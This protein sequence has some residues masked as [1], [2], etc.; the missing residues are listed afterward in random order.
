MITTDDALWPVLDRYLAGECTAAEAALVREWLL[1]DPQEHQL[2]LADIQRIRNVVKHRPQV[3]SAD[4]MWRNVAHELSVMVSSNRPSLASHAVSQIREQRKIVLPQRAIFKTYPRRRGMWSVATALL[5]GLVVLGIGRSI[6]TRH[7]HR[8]TA[9]SSLI[10]TTGNGE[11]ANI[12]LP[13]GGTVALNVASRLEVPLDYMSGDRTVWLTGEGLFTIPHHDRVPLTVRTDVAVVRVLGTSFVVR[14]YA[15]D[16]ATL[17]A[18]REGK[19]MVDGAVVTAAHLVEVGHNGVSPVRLSDETP[20]MFAT[21]VLTLNGVSLLDAIPELD[22]WYG[23]D[24]RLGSPTLATHH[25]KGEFAAGSLADLGMLEFA[26][27]VRVV[28]EGRVLTLY[29]RH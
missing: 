27:G 6:G 23:A 15:T 4:S 5:L 17:V 1:M 18:V 3:R 7:G 21:G 8:A 25:L 16:T 10:Y 14:R 11:R 19:V 24:I 13:D 2:M 22:R 20:F 9:Q 26:L 28:R 12:T 29:P